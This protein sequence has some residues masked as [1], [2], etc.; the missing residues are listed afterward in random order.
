MNLSLIYSYYAYIA[1]ISIISDFWVWSKKS[2]YSITLPKKIF[3]CVLKRLRGS[4][5]CPKYDPKKFWQLVNKIEN[6]RQVRY[7]PYIGLRV[8]SLQMCV[9]TCLIVLFMAFSRGKF[10]AESI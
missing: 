1:L 6:G 9:K 4:L 10:H 5:E 2:F 8:T 3:R 7:C